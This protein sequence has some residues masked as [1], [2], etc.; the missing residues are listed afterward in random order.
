MANENAAKTELE[1]YTS[2]LHRFEAHK[3]A[4]DVAARDRDNIF[5]LETFFIDAYCV[6]TQDLAFLRETLSVLVA[7]RLTIAWAYV[8]DFY[9]N[10][11][12]INAAERNMWQHHLS[13]FEMHVDRLQEQYEKVT[14]FRFDLRPTESN[15]LSF[16]GTSS[17]T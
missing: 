3:K 12:R 13:E 15:F 1:R 8:R 16:L 2:F 5:D 17:W 7:G 11:K 14:V 4:A 6:S 9:A 10:E